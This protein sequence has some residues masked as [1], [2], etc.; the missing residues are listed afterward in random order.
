MEGLFMPIFNEVSNKSGCKFHVIQFTWGDKERT[1]IT[2]KAAEKLG[3][4]YTSFPILKKPSASIG[5]LLTIFRGILFLSNYIKAND[6]QVVMPRSTLPG[7][8]VNR[9]KSKNF[10]ILFDADGLP[11]E[12]RVDFAN[13]STKSRIYRFLKKE[14]TK[15]LKKADRVITRSYKAIQFHLKTLGKDYKDKFSVVY[16][17]RPENIFTISKN[18]IDEV[19]SELQIGKDE[20]VFIYCGSLD[21]AKYATNEMLI[22]FDNYLKVNQ[23]SKF[24]ILTGSADYAMSIIP[25]NLKDKIVIKN[26]E[27][28]EVPS[29][30]NIADVGL[31]LITPK[32]SMQAVSA[33]KIGEY[34]LSGLPVIASKGIGDSEAILSES[35]ACFIYNHQDPNR[36]EKAVRFLQ[37][38]N[39]KKQEEL[40]N[41]GMKY[42]SLERSAESYLEALDQ[43]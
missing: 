38:S 14:E 15:M 29:Y 21:G 27:F 18:K 25:D 19:R 9:L 16:N 42:F 13:L 8:M 7:I 23:K 33:I 17:G 1:A 5:S 12:E 6:I 2:Q 35:P 3:M 32:K 43:L 41:L 39:K 40:R 26:V 10:K 34:L 31:A 11:I 24:I 4:K 28:S 20:F 22:L 36:V 37:R 30:L